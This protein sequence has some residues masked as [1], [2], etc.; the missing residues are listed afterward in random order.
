MKDLILLNPKS[1]AAMRWAPP[2]NFS[3]V[4]GNAILPVQAFESGRIASALPLALCKDASLASGWALMA[5]CGQE[6]RVNAMVDANGQWRAKAVPECIRYLPFALKG[7]G[8]GKALAGIDPRYA[9]KVLITGDNA[10]PLYGED[11]Q[12]HPLARKRVEALTA[13]QPKV[14]RTQEILESFNEA[15]LIVPWPDSVL[16]AGGVTIK[17]LH[18][19]DEKK[20]SQ[21]DDETFLSLRKSGALAVAYSCLLSLYQIR[22][23]V[24]NAG[25]AKPVSDKAVQTTGDLDL[26]FLN[27]GDTIKFGPLH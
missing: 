1:G 8:G 7:L 3:F 9:G 2:A 6:S 14:R 16:K 23:L 26:E 22:S 5:V 18:T 19:I 10:A 20:L 24:G 17:G 27:D 15:G 25:E 21:L 12:L 4:S 11:G 13:H